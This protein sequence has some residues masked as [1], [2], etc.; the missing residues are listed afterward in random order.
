MRVLN[1]GETTVFLDDINVYVPY[2]KQKRP[3]EIA[4][5]VASGSRKLAIALKQGLLIDVTAGVPECLPT[6]QSSTLRIIKDSVFS[7]S[8]DALSYFKDD[9]SMAVVWTGPAAEASGYANLNR[10]FMLGLESSGVLVKYVPVRSYW[11]ADQPI[12]RKLMGLQLN[13][14]PT[15]AP[16]VYGMPAPVCEDAARHRIFLTMMETR[17]LHEDYVERCNAADEIVV[18]SRWCKRVFEESGV[19]KP[20]HVVSIGVDTSEYRPGL[21]PLRFFR[22]RKPFTFL[23]VFQW[24][25]RKGYD[26][27]LRAFCEEFDK[28][29]DVSLVISSKLFG[30]TD[31]AKSQIIKNEIKRLTAG[32]PSRPPIVYF[33]D[34]L[35]DEVMPRLYAAADCFVLVSRGEGFGL[36]YVEAGACGVPVIGSNYS[37][38]TDFLT[39]ENSYLVDV[40]SF[41]LDKE[42]EF[43]SRFFQGIEF[44]TFGRA[45]ID[46][47]RLHMRRVYENREEAKNKARNLRADVEQN[48]D[49]R[50]CVGQMREKLTE[51]FRLL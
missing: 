4:T 30:E 26:V 3:V 29:E 48:Y 8:H 43:V 20:V 25:M 2:D 13:M 21:E 16:V 45:A 50:V 35:T 15:N 41:S 24:S 19:T 47:T 27:L 34:T 5:A 18:P 14:A 31:E 32:F 39:G 1:I 42:V 10:Q 6:P 7:K 28:S 40:D 23:S 37:G 33:G 9:G 44:P 46:Q 38:Q 11:D 49:W 51:T 36:P 22:D 17:R 12:V